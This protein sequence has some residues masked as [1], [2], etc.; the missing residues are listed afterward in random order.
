MRSL[1]PIILIGAAV[2]IFFGPTRS[3]LR[4]TEPL[5]AT[6]ADLEQ[7]LE[8]ARKIQSARE[9]LQAQYNSFKSSDLANLQK[10]LPSHVDNV[11][12]VI[13][14]NG[15]ASTYGMIFRNIEVEQ[16]QDPIANP[17]AGTIRGD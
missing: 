3:A 17:G 14:I 2:A 1:I 8:S 10:L 16:V 6:R 9:S 11:R 5:S 13:D 15:M 12:L 7:A 4:A